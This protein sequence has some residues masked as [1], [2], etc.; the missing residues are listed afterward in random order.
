MRV[1][2]IRQRVLEKVREVAAG[3]D[4]EATAKIMDYSRAVLVALAS[5]GAEEDV[6][7]EKL[8]VGTTTAAHI[9]SLH[10]EYVRDLVRR[11]VIKAIKENGE[12]R[13]AFP[14]LVAFLIGIKRPEPGRIGFRDIRRSG[15]PL[16]RQPPQ[17]P[18]AGEQP[19]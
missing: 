3:G 5:Y 17:E 16:W 9:L 18:Q 6:N 8:T 2:E 19:A 14:N 12:Y 7:L 11:N 15:W 10:P 13:I 1:A 4:E